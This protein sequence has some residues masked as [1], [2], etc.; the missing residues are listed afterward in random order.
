MPAETDVA[1]LKYAVEK[2]HGGI[3]VFVQSL[4]V[5]EKFQGK[6]V[7]Q[8]IVHVFDF[9]EHSTAERA[10]AWFL[11]G[12]GNKERQLFAMVHTDTVDSPRKAV[13]AAIL[14]EYQVRGLASI[15]PL[16]PTQK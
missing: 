7:W 12:E 14:A 3:A 5:I 1:E 10:Y 4:P 16:V 13:R 2:T 6:T 9:V 11:R 15:F 8:E